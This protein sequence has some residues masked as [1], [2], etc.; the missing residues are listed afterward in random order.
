ME[1]TFLLVEF[2]D[3]RNITSHSLSPCRHSPHQRCSSAASRAIRCIAPPPHPYS[4]GHGDGRQEPYSGHFDNV[5]DQTQS[6]GLFNFFIKSTRRSTSAVYKPRGMGA[7]VCV[8]A[9]Q[10]Y[11][12]T[13]AS[14]LIDRLQIIVDDTPTS[15]Q[16]LSMQRDPWPHPCPSSGIYNLP[17]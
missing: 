3:S 17:R 8:S 12:L 4:A 1:S 15:H 5:P 6:C 14:P 11:P 16:I 2:S 7:I 9:N 13:P 10:L